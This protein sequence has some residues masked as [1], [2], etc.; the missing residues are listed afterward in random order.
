MRI[1]PI[2]Y[3]IF[4]LTLYF[5]IIF[6]FKAAGFWSV[7]GKTGAGGEQVQPSAGDVNTIK[8][9][10]TLEQISET[11]Q[12]PT[13][14]IIQQFDLPADTPASTAIKDLE[15]EQFSVANLRAWLQ[16]RTQPTIEAPQVESTTA[17]ST[18]TATQLPAA[19]PTAEAT[20]TPEPTVHTAVDRTITGQTTFQQLLDWGVA[21]EAVEQ[22]IGAA[23][24]S[25]DT[26]IKDHVTAKGLQFGT[27]K[28]QLQALVDQVK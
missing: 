1:K 20:A 15:S 6:G 12:V 28:S 2:V 24:P 11:Y 14:E 7:T 23:L 16:I 27:V 3:G 22:V 13:A 17:E 21:Q 5:G 26:V 8:G 10:M 4:V 18:Q 9:W 25:P 19:S